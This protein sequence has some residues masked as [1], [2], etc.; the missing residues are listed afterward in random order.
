MAVKYC[1][2][3]CRTMEYGKPSAKYV[4]STQG[5]AEGEGGSTFGSAF[6]SAL[7]GEGLGGVA[8]AGTGP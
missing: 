2:E 8:W 6:G 5:I 7:D 3:I 1:D 4:E